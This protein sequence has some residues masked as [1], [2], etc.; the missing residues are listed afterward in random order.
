MARRPEEKNK[1]MADHIGI[2]DHLSSSYQTA[3]ALVLNEKITAVNIDEAAK[4]EEYDSDV[5]RYVGI[6]LKVQKRKND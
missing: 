3:S 1:F 4:A 5:I 2:R 6:L